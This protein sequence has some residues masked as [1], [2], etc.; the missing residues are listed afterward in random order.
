[1]DGVLKTFGRGVSPA[2]N[3]L[4]SRNITNRVSLFVARDNFIY[5]RVLLLYNTSSS[6][7]EYT[8]WLDYG[9]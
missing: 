6:A 2:E 1:M 7:P 3:S 9:G 8:V 4:S 5:P